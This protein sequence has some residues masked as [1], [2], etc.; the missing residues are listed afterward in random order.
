LLLQ[1]IVVFLLILA[2][3]AAAQADYIPP[4]DF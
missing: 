3:A 2:L 4:L 1:L